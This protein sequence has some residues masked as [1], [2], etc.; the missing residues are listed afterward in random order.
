MNLKRP[1]KKIRNVEISL[2]RNKLFENWEI[3]T[4]KQMRHQSTTYT[5]YFAIIAIR[6]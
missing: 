4:F 2:Q 3:S 6:N 1:N 5:L